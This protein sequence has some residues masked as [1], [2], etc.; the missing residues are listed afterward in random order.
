MTC[1]I[2][3]AYGEVI[4]KITILEIKLS[5]CFS[6]EQQTNIQRE[7][8]LIY[9]YF[10]EKK[11]DPE[12]MHLYHQLSNVNNQ[13]WILEDTIR[14]KTHKQEFDNDFIQIAKCIHETNDQRYIIKKQINQLCDSVIQEEKIYTT[15]IHSPIQKTDANLF[16]ECV[17]LYNNGEYIK[18]NQLLKH[19]CD[20]L[21][22]NTNTYSNLSIQIFFSYNVSCY[23]IHIT[24]IY[25][26]KLEEIIDF[27]HSTNTFFPNEFI[28]NTKRLYGFV[29]LEEENYLICK[30][31]T[32]YVQVVTGSYNDEY[33][34]TPDNMGFFKQTDTNK[35]LLIYCSGGIG[36]IVMFIRF[37]KVIC[38]EEKTK[39]NNRIIIIMNDELVWMFQPWLQGVCQII[40][41]ICSTM[42]KHFDYHLNLTQLIYYYKPEIESFNKL[43]IDYYLE[44]LLI[45]NTIKKNKKNIIINW[46]CNKTNVEKKHNCSI[47]LEEL[48]TICDNNEYNWFSVQKNTTEQEREL[49]EKANVIHLNLDN[50]GHA[51]KDTIEL[52]GNIDLVI[53]VDTSIVHIAGTANV[54]CW[55]LLTVGCEWRWTWKNKWYPKVKLFRQEQL[56]DWSNVLDSIKRELGCLSFGKM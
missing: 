12:F 44:P 25:R 56:Y 31:Y 30:K 37:L 17:I 22:T 3:C 20:K 9:S 48:I 29:G 50:D 14:E 13:L 51:F 5:K 28:M 15:T 40:P 10:E 54:D 8:N 55:C 11:H 2:Q 24:N 53:S 49:L 1:I 38:I 43:F 32:K 42:I 34:I 41:T 4:D 47:P 39:R 6:I 46:S 18:N 16:D 27:I 23:M 35:C 33:I 19:L 52:L 26:H 7:Y 45:K 36:D 21:N